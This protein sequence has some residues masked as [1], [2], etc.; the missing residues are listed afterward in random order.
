MNVHKKIDSAEAAVYLPVALSKLRELAKL[1][2]PVQQT[3]Q[4]GDVTCRLSHY[5]HSGQ[6]YVHLYGGGA[7]HYEFFTTDMV[8]LVGTSFGTPPYTGSLLGTYVGGHGVKV[9]LG[10]T[11]HSTMAGS[12]TGLNG[13]KL[14]SIFDGAESLNLHYAFNNQ[15]IAFKQMWGVAK[16]GAEPQLTVSVTCRPDHHAPYY[17]SAYSSFTKNPLVLLGDILWDIRQQKY[18]SHKL[19]KMITPLLPAPKWWR[20]GAT[21]LVD[22]VSVSVV[23]DA[24]N[25]FYFFKTATVPADPNLSL[26]GATYVP[27]AECVV[28]TQEEYLPD[29]VAKCSDD[30]LVSQPGAYAWSL[31]GP[32]TDISVSTA[33]FEANPSVP[34]DA[35][36][37]SAPDSAMYQANQSLWS[38]SSDGRKAVAVVGYDRGPLTWQAAEM[39]D[40]AAVNFWRYAALEPV[41]HARYSASGSADLRIPARIQPF[42]DP[43]LG[44]A[45]A[46]AITPALLELNLNVAIDVSGTLSASI[47]VRSSD[48]EGWYVNADYAYDNPEL[49]AQGIQADSLVTGEIRSYVHDQNP[50]YLYDMT[51]FPQKCS[52]VSTYRVKAAGVVWREFAI[53]NTWTEMHDRQLVSKDALE[54]PYV[55]LCLYSMIAHVPTVTIGGVTMPIYGGKTATS[56]DCGLSGPCEYPYSAFVTDT[57]AG[58][59]FTEGQTQPNHADFYTAISACDLRSLSFVFATHYKNYD[60]GTVDRGHVVYAFGGVKSTW[61]VGAAYLD[62]VSAGW[63]D[64]ALVKI[65]PTAADM[66]AYASDG[67]YWVRSGGDPAYT[68]YRVTE[69]VRTLGVDIYS[70]AH[71]SLWMLTDVPQAHLATYPSGAYGI[72]FGSA[73][74]YGVYDMIKYKHNGV[75]VLT[76]HTDMFNA[77]YEQARTQSDYGSAGATYQYGAMASAGGWV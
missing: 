68:H 26:Y 35:W 33:K 21:M 37:S 38:F 77:A 58:H 4:F 64:A 18:T 2:H 14:T 61:G 36:Q 32:V 22:G 49:Q 16:T 55:G 19:A 3:L 74:F 51:Y 28:V 23:T 54:D 12:W 24:F 63:T 72:N 6:Q 15:K 46:R 56:A 44:L 65:Y 9:S 30:T 69:S 41:K 48:K 70:I 27:L 59:Q 47:T 20:R 53:G 17:T 62:Y 29:W 45:D 1:S 13:A 60:A 42:L 40:D 11:P 43:G 76:S 50:T 34:Y 8:S 71:S 66:E 31:T 5:P 73:G 10:A 75:E 52:A 67:M 39:V 57:T 7:F 25:N